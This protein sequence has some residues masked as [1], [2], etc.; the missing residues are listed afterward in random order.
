MDM[1]NNTCEYCTT[2]T[3][4]KRKTM[5]GFKYPFSKSGRLYGYAIKIGS[6]FGGSKFKTPRL[7]LFYGKYLHATIKIQY[8]PFCG[9]K[10]QNTQ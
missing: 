5:W 1:I 7:M 9:Q 3:K 8:C 6:S 4:R 2:T 10:L